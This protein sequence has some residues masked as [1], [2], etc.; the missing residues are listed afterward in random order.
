MHVDEGSGGDGVYAAWEGYKNEEHV[1]Q[2][3]YPAPPV[4]HAVNRYA[5]YEDSKRLQQ[6]RNNAGPLQLHLI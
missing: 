6:R 2:V 3:F 4:N 1:L 5:D